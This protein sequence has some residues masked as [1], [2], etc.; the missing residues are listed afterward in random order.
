MKVDNS[1]NLSRLNIVT[2]D[3]FFKE[4]ALIEGEILEIFD[5]MATIDIKGLGILKAHTEKNLDDQKG[6]LLT[7]IVK[8]SLPNKIELKPILNNVEGKESIEFAEELSDSGNNYL[9]DILREFHIKEDSTTIGFLDSLIKYN[10]QINKET[11]VNGVKVLDKLEQI[12]N[13]DKDEI[14]ILANPNGNKAN[15]TKENTGDPK[16]EIFR[17]AK[18]YASNFEE[19]IFNVGKEDIRNFIILDKNNSNKEPNLTSM[20]KEYLGS[21]DKNIESDIIKTVSFFIK[22]NI[23]PTINNI[24]YFHELKKDPSLFSEDFKILEEKASK[25]F[26]NADKRLIINNENLKNPIEESIIKFK[27][28]LDKTFDHTKENSHIMDKKAQNDVE[29]LRDKIEFLK[30]MNKELTFVYLP[31]KL[32]QDNYNGAITFL[33]KKKKEN[34][35]HNKINMFINLKTKR[36]GNVKIY[37]EVLNETINI[38]F[39]DINKED[40]NLFKSKEYELKLLTESTGYKINTIEYFFDNNENILDFII[41][42]TKP[43][44]YLDVQV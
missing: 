34:N 5:D 35:F 38:K 3:K 19:K 9:I 15:I 18:D 28:L 11:V 43:I 4:G 25:S 29:E 36:L 26:T 44:Y 6:K 10:V 13:I 12:L 23:R 32:E 17:I 16:E 1:L 2:D 41:V 27:N 31:L 20:V 14:I 7:F 21:L 30:E 24:R 33:K 42:N 40:L 39:N 22:Y 37:C 8:L